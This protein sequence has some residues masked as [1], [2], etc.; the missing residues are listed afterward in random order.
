[1]FIL[2]LKDLF[3]VFFVGVL[4]LLLVGKLIMVEFYKFFEI[5]LVV[6]IIYWL[7]VVFYFWV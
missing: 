1:M 7:I 2:L 5:Y 3:V 6:G 4:E